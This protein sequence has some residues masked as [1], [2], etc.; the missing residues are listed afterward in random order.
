M[1]LTP[2]GKLF[3]LGVV[4]VPK[5]VKIWFSQPLCRCNYCFSQQFS[6]SAIYTVFEIPG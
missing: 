4:C 1:S 5:E 2:A 3:A 6:S